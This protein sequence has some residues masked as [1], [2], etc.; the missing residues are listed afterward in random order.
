MPSPGHGDA[1][2]K[3]NGLEIFCRFYWA[4]MHMEMFNTIYIFSTL[5]HRCCSQLGIHSFSP[6]LSNSNWMF[7]WSLTS[8]KL[9]GH[10]PLNQRIPHCMGIPNGPPPAAH[11]GAAALS[12]GKRNGRQWWQFIAGTMGRCCGWMT[13]CVMTGSNLREWVPLFFLTLHF[14]SCWF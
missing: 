8:N 2:E 12:S 10:S 7:P 3:W 13:W 11:I 5:S 6:S 14:L 1:H 4:G 9:T